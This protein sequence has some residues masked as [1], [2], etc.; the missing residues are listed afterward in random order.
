MTRLERLARRAHDTRVR[1][2]VA[3]SLT[4]GA[5]ASTL[6]AGPGAGEWF[7]G[8]VVAYG[9]DVKQRV[10]GLEAGIHPVSAE[11]AVQLAT[12]VRTLMC[13]DITVSVTGVGGPDPQDGIPAGT[14][15][16]GWASPQDAGHRLLQL[17]GDP[18]RVL[19]GSIEAALQT[20][21][22]LVG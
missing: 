6:G 16:L 3:E 22:H 4:C 15:Y 8:G 21:E 1:L 13:A 14:V 17:P 20:F 7:A 12:A 11:C 5:I 19:E 18:E 2:A 9:T 10:L